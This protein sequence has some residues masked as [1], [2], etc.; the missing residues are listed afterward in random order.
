MA[1]VL[2]RFAYAY[3][4]CASPSRENALQQS[5]TDKHNNTRTSS[6]ET[7]DLLPGAGDQEQRRDGH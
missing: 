2:T 5:V 3:R 4:N 7:L 1:N 6:H